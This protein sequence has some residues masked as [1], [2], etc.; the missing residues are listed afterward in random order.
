MGLKVKPAKEGG[1]PPMPA[2][3]YQGVCYMCIDLGT[4]HNAMFNTDQPK[5][6]IGWEIQEIRLDDGRPR[7]I[8]KEFTNSMHEKAN[9]R[10][11]LESW[12]GR[13]LTQKEIDGEFDMKN[14]LGANAMI[15]VIH[16]K[17]GK[18]NTYAT[19]NNVTKI[20]KGMQKLEPENE[21]Q[22][23][24][25]EDDMEIPANIPEWIVSKIQDSYEYQEMMDSSHTDEEPPEFL[26]M[27]DMPDAAE[28]VPF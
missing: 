19:V 5:V 11:T 9:L 22:Y 24:S 1:I 18:G 16:R 17:S 2:G 27:P 4:Q 21:F 26:D 25:F 15:Q 12:A 6:I 10:Q 8:S 13:E 7:A 23:F 14:L 20:Y 3:T 28:D